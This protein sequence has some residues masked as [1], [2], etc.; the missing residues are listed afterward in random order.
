MEE[1]KDNSLLINILTQLDAEG[2]IKDKNHPLVDFIDKN[3]KKLKKS[4][5][6]YSYT[7]AQTLWTEFK[8][9][10]DKIY[11]F[12][13]T[14]K[15]DES[16]KE[17]I[18]KEY[19]IHKENEELNNISP[20]FICYYFSRFLNFSVFMIRDYYTLYQILENKNLPNFSNEN[21]FLEFSNEEL[22]L[23][24][25]ETIKNLNLDENYYICPFLT[26][27]NLLYTESS[28]KEYFLLSEIFLVTN[29]MENEIELE[30]MNKD[31]KLKEWLIPEFAKNKLKLSFSSNIYCLGKIFNSIIFKLNNSHLKLDEYPIYKKLID[32]CTND[33]IKERWSIEQIQNFINENNFEEIKNE[34]NKI[35]S[36][37]FNDTLI[38]KIQ[39]YDEQKDESRSFIK[40]YELFSDKKYEQNNN[41]TSKITIANGEKLIDN[42][43]L[44]ELKEEKPPLLININISNEKEKEKDLEKNDNDDKPKIIL[45]KQVEKNNNIINNQIFINRDNNINIEEKKDNIIGNIIG[46]EIPEDNKK[47]INNKEKNEILLNDINIRNNNILEIKDNKDNNSIYSENIKINEE[48]K[49]ENCDKE[50]KNENSNLKNQKIEEEKEINTNKEDEKEIFN[51]N[52]D[53]INQNELDLENNEEYQKLKL[54]VERKKKEFKEK[55]MKRELENKKKLEEETK[56]KE[57]EN[58]K[59]ESL[60]KEKLKKLEEENERKNKINRKRKSTRRNERKIEGRIKK[61]RKGNI[62]F[63]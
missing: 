7:N 56:L 24:C 28:G 1:N 58:K 18:K 47:D 42:N 9:E 39:N 29:S 38:S 11:L 12:R 27:Y 53:Y 45:F 10:E 19:K 60:E 35:D 3:G 32:N 52:K 15:L 54:E 61:T 48:N 30:I 6:K 16:A 20:E 63:R 43:K 2:E 57:E 37:G 55:Q 26:P 40:N 8:L 59:K 33:N 36:F 5:I 49:F 25:S 34:V 17:L 41:D 13:I 50:I 44:I 14:K 4:T 22:L 62:R 51:G 31:S 46:K 21:S 23:S